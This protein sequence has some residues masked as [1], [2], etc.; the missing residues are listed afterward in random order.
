M[1]KI[2][3]LSIYL[4]VGCAITIILS[5]PADARMKGASV[6]FSANWAHYVDG[7]LLD[8]GKYYAAS[9][10][11][12]LEGMEGNNP[13]IVIHDFKKQVSLYIYV[14]HREYIQVPMEPARLRYDFAQF[15]SPCPP[16]ARAE[17]IGKDTLNS[18]EVEKWTCDIPGEGPETVWY[19]TRLQTAILSQGDDDYIQLTD[20]QE[21][22]QPASLFA[23]P[24]N[25]TKSD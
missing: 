16:A 14:P 25:F 21:G 17:R 19:D 22:H 6:P 4:A 2:W 23:P 1:M 7:E 3:N 11:V 20:I 12:R 8:G 13:Y 9:Q 18:R 24:A 15:G 10:S 5:L